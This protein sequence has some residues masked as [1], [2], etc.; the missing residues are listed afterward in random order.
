[1]LQ[2]KCAHNFHLGRGTVP[3]TRSLRWMDQEPGARMEVTHMQLK[4]SSAHSLF[5]P[6]HL[7][8][9]SPSLSFFF[10]LLMKKQF[11]KF[12]KQKKKKQLFSKTKVGEV[13]LKCP[14]ESIISYALLLLA[15]LSFVPQLPTGQKSRNKL[16]SPSF[17]GLIRKAF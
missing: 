6:Y 2:K 11:R 8:W 5:T 9:H 14:F 4:S 13:I 12:F 1:M 3:V 7:F 17:S 15:L 16:S 10:F